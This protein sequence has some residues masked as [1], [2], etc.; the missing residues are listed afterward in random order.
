MGNEGK[1]SILVVDDRS[2]NLFALET[3]LRELD[4][5]IVTVASGR[6]ALERCLQQEFAVILLDVRMPIMDGFETATRIRQCERSRTTPIIFVTAMDRE[7]R[8]VFRGYS[9]GAVDYIF[10]PII[11]DILRAKVS[12]F[13]SLYKRTKEVLEMKAREEQRLARELAEAREA[14]EQLERELRPPEGFAASSQATVAARLYGRAPLRESAAEV[15]GRMMER[16]RGLIDLA[17]E[18]RTHKVDHQVSLKTRDLA[19]ELAFLNAGPRDVVEIHQRV[20]KGRV[21]KEPA[22]KAKALL[23]EGR[24]IVL[25]L[26][27][28]LVSC[29]RDQC[30]GARRVTG[31]AAAIKGTEGKEKA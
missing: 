5:E 4:I 14:Q 20:M 24:L 2:E 27:G 18:Q 1:A 12:V 9:L 31:T 8:D 26:M 3:T 29:Y 21:N 30:F 13:V 6:E 17:L 15:H 28:Y 16:Y 22:L 7:E 11:A 25:E 23:E 10:K 19:E